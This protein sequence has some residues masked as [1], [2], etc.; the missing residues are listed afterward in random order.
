MYS[1]QKEQ[2]PIKQFLDLQNTRL[3]IKNSKL[4][5]FFFLLS[6]SVFFFEKKILIISKII[7][8]FYWLF[9]FILWENLI[10]IFSN[11]K[12]EY[13]ESSWF[14]SKSWQKPLFFLKND[15]VFANQNLKNNIRQ[16]KKVL[17]VLLFFLFFNI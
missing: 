2:K 6:L 8:T 12:I 14:D 3:V 1:I 15:N 9:C 17:C 13:E 4:I 16:Y 5:F 10:Y 11:S 7:F